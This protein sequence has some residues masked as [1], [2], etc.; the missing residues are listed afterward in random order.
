MPFHRGYTELMRERMAALIAAYFASDP[1]PIRSLHRRHG[2]THLIVDRRHFEVPPPYFAP[3]DAETRGMFALARPK[4][5]ELQ[6]II[7][8]G[9]GIE[10]GGL[11]LVDLSRI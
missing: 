10:T 9:G 6:R 2:V 5:F 8:R 11:V 1:E 7:E 4:G 3:F